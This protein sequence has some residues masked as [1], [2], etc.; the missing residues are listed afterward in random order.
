MASC[1]YLNTL[2]VSQSS[3]NPIFRG[4][5]IRK[6]NSSEQRLIKYVHLHTQPIRDLAFHPEAHDGIIASA[7]LDKTLR[8]TSLLNDSVSLISLCCYFCITGCA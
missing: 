8:L 2:C 7:S 5:G 3:T 6:V 1:D 4:F